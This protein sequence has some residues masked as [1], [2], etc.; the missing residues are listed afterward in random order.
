[1]KKNKRKK[2]WNVC[3]ECDVLFESSNVFPVR[4]EDGKRICGSCLKNIVR[5]VIND[6]GKRG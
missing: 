5:K 1:M 6:V 4:T 3:G 2:K